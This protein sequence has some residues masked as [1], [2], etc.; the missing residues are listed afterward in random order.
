MDD[1]FAGFLR[2]ARG[3]GRK[4]LIADP[5]GA[6]ATQIFAADPA[7]IGPGYAWLGLACFTLQIYF[8]FAGYSDMAIGLAARWASG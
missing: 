2:F 1:I 8:D 6:F 4:L 3:I 5:L 7:T